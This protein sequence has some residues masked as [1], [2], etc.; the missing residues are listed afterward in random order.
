MN[1]R[2]FLAFLVSLSP[3][4]AL[5]RAGMGATLPTLPLPGLAA[6]LPAAGDTFFGT[7]RYMA[8]L[9]CTTPGYNAVID[10]GDDSGDV[11]VPGPPTAGDW[12][13]TVGDTDDRA[14]PRT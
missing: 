14:E 4:L 3:G 5:A 6:W 7:L 9:E 8:V 10:L 12:V 1:R 11:F 13:F 2:R